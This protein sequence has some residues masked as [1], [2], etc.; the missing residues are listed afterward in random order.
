MLAGTAEPE[1]TSG[2]LH[3]QIT[4][5]A[6]AVEEADDAAHHLDHFLED[7]A[8][9]S[10]DLAAEALDLLATGNFHEAEDKVQGMLEGMPHQHHQH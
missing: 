8:G 4:L 6:I 5:S 2:E 3:L 1:L 7:A 9:L 10:R